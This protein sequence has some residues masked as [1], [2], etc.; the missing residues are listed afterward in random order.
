MITS[1]LQKPSSTEQ[2]LVIIILLLLLVLALVAWNWVTTLPGPIKSLIGWA[3]LILAVLLASELLPWQKFVV[4]AQGYGAVGMAW[5][6]A[7]PLV[8]LLVLPATLF[9]SV[10]WNNPA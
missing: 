8:V 2:Y 7:H 10:F 6:D 3:S 1:Y 5:M 9:G 4:L